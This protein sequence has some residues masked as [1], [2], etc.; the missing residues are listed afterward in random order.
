MIIMVLLWLLRYFKHNMAF[1]VSS[2][3]SW[4]QTYLEFRFC[5][6]QIIGHWLCRIS[7]IM[8][9]I[10]R[11]VSCILNGLP[12]LAMR[13]YRLG[14]WVDCDMV[15]LS[16]YAV[17]RDNRLDHR[18]LVSQSLSYAWFDNVCTWTKTAHQIVR[19]RLYLLAQHTYHKFLACCYD[20]RL[21]SVVFLNKNIPLLFV[22]LQAWFTSL[23]RPIFTYEIIG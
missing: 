23:L 13:P 16:W 15:E 12:T 10:P 8:R 4:I 17:R 9:P 11:I 5:T 18:F 20:C 1:I 21:W 3:N 2:G 22:H 19:L 7:Y 14:V 6:P